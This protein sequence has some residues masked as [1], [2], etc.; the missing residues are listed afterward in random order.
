MNEA[1]KHKEDGQNTGS[2][3]TAPE[4][5]KSARMHLRDGEQ[6]RAYQ[7]LREA[8]THYPENPIV[9]SYYGYVQA[10]VDKRFQSGMAACRKSLAVFKPSDATSARALY[11][12]LYLNLG[13][14]CAAANR[15]K[16]AVEAFTKGL[17]HDKG[18]LELKKEM[19][20]LGLRK[21]PPV[22]FLSRSNPINKYLGMM[23]HR[24]GGS[25]AQPRRTV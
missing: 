8:M 19:K 16:D 3:P 18:H 7:L 12:I 21:Q 11:P 1:D 25:P 17:K 24:A 20:A 22:P 9:L 2:T 14:A 15:K 13:R 6:N 5:V 23:L 10:V 4:Y